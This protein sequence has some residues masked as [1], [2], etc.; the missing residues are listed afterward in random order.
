VT[1]PTINAFDQVAGR[2]AEKSET[3]TGVKVPEAVRELIAE[4]VRTGY[5][6]AWSAAE[7]S[8]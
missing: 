5:E 2:I 4:G 6:M 3:R 8:R 1:A 7:S